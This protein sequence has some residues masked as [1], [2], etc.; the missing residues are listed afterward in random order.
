MVKRFMRDLV[1]YDPYPKELP[2]RAE[3]V[4]PRLKSIGKLITPEPGEIAANP[5]ARSARLRIAE[6]LAA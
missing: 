1:R 2:V 4:R 6:K 3:L 5:R